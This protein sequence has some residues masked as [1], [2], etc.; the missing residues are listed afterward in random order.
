MG[1]S[2]ETRTRFLTLVRTRID[3]VGPGAAILA[4]MAVLLVGAP[5]A[6]R[7]NP[8]NEAPPH[9]DGLTMLRV[10]QGYN[11]TK[12]YDLTFPA[13]SDEACE[14]AGVGV[15]TFIALDHGVWANG[16]EGNALLQSAYDEARAA[17]P[18]D[19]SYVPCYWLR[20]GSASDFFSGLHRVWPATLKLSF[21]RLRSAMQK[22][23]CRVI[24]KRLRKYPRVDVPRK[25]L[26]RRVRVAAGGACS[27]R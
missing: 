3:T 15:L 21:K 22:G 5:G 7:A 18:G 20:F 16:P 17:N 9:F 6:A 26:L 2:P 25:K 10:A 24:I 8:S 13:R 12:A 4:A 23:D 27:R 11:L 1:Y 19:P 14:I